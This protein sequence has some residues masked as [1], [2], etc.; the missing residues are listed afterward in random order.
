MA[1]AIIRPTWDEYGMMFAQVAAT[2]AACS[3]RQVGAAIMDARHDI[4]G[5]GYNGVAAGRTNCSDG[6]CP[7]G[8]LSYEEC[9][10]YTSYDNCE[11]YHAEDNALW[12]A[13]TRRVDLT[14]CTIYVTH[15]PCEDCAYKIRE[16]GISRVVSSR[17]LYRTGIRIH[18]DVINRIWT[19]MGS[20]LD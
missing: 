9:A 17:E 20:R 14:H 3:R 6:G 12:F 13:Q 7:R 8:L 16:A 19:R 5:T 18:R 4:V 11:G 1:S 2:R 15:D 10:A